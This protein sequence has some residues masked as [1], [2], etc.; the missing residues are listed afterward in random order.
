MMRVRWLAGAQ[1]TRLLSDKPKM[2]LVAI[3]AGC[4]NRQ[5]TFVDAFWLS[6]VATTEVLCNL[7]YSEITTG[8][9]GCFGL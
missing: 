9:F 3:P 7:G 1:E 5:D 8:E 2:L 4:S 6:T